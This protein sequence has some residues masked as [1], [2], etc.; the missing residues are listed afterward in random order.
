MDQNKEVNYRSQSASSRA[1]NAQSVDG[2]RS[3]K[4]PSDGMF[5]VRKPAPPKIT[6]RPTLGLD[7][8]RPATRPIQ[9]PRPVSPKPTPAIKAAAVPTIPRSASVRQT[10]VAPAARNQARTRLDPAV[11][12]LPQRMPRTTP[13]SRQPGRKRQKSFFK[14][15]FARPKTWRGVVWR[16]AATLFIVLLGTG[17]FLGWKAYKDVRRVFRGTTTVAALSAKTVVPDLLKTEGDGRVNILLMGIGGPGHD[18]PDLTDTMVVLSIDPVNNSAAMLSIPRD[19]WVQQPIN[20]FGKQQKINAAYESGK[21]HVTG[22]LDPTNKNAAAVQAGFANVDQVVKNV[23]G[24]NV[25]YHV[26]VNFQAFRQAVDT[27]GG[28]TVNVPTDLVDPTMAW[29]NHWNPV[30][31]KAGV[32]QMNGVQ[33]LLYARSRET[34]SDFAR[35]QRQRQILVALKDK[36]LT[37]GTLSNPAAIS[38]LLS[39]FGDNVYSDMSTDAAVRVYGIMKKI[40]DTQ[41]GSLAMTEPPNKLIVTDHVGNISVDRPVAG[42]DN[43]ADIQTYVHSQLLDG[44]ITKEHA[45]VTVLAP[46]QATAQAATDLLKS[47]GYNVTTTATTTQPLTAP[48]IV[49]LSHGK[50]AFT[51]HYLRNRYGVKA[52]TSLPAGVSLTDPATKF[53]IMV[54]K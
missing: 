33:A 52:V 49:D 1:K 28:V 24:I 35:S 8:I 12:A 44:Y 6:G 20:Y 41:I 43:Y 29:E 5:L 42:F 14:R 36:V 10:P 45:A 11:A 19:L 31:A 16:S 54:P 53:V 9:A 37:L 38:G 26:L 3:A 50:D 4:I 34:S 47:Y 13:I 39:A 40:D 17:G 2:I 30:L 21:Y 27:V 22:Q 15:L 18:G 48:V 7:G 46:E 25:G 23:L 32:Q 51:L